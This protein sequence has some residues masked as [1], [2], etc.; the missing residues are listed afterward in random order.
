MLHFNQI[1]K[2]NNS[3]EAKKDAKYVYTNRKYTLQEIY[4][5]AIASGAVCCSTVNHEIFRT[6]IWNHSFPHWKLS[7]QNLKFSF[8]HLRVAFFGTTVSVV[9]ECVDQAVELNASNMWRSIQNVTENDIQSRI[10]VCMYVEPPQQSVIYWFHCM[11]RNRVCL[12][13]ESIEIVQFCMH[14]WNLHPIKLNDK[15]NW[16][17]V[18]SIMF[19]MWMICSL[20]Y[21]TTCIPFNVMAVVA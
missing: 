15:A 2:S 8:E 20:L 7:S 6:W 1:E 17:S 9:A 12:W 21:T 13:L 16:N 19:S 18:S 5:T 3:N 10:F 11:G 4:F 14:P